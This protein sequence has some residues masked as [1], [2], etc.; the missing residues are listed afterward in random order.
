MGECNI[1][2]PKTV[3]DGTEQTL[4]E[5]TELGEYSGY[6]F[7]DKMVEGDVI[8]MSAY[9]KDPEDNLYK[10]YGEYPYIDAQEYP[11]VLIKPQIGKIGFKVTAKQTV[12]TYRELT[13][14]WFKR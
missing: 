8:T 3:M 1:K 5:S 11:T 14:M 2:M 9:I 10:K 6:V 13:H 12:G 4:F 7:L